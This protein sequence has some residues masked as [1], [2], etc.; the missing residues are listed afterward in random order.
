MT[1][2]R[3][4][5]PRH[6]SHRRCRGRDRSL[7]AMCR[8]DAASWHA[9]AEDAGAQGVHREGIAVS[10]CLACER[11][12]EPRLAWG[13]SCWRHAQVIKGDLDIYIIIDEV[14]CRHCC[15][16]GLFRLTVGD[17]LE[18]PTL[19]LIETTLL[20]DAYPTLPN[21]AEQ[22]HAGLLDLN[23]NMT[24]R[25]QHGCIHLCLVWSQKD[26]GNKCLSK[27]IR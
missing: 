20:P 11:G 12:F 16:I 17:L 26:R 24:S 13:A 9:T 23:A 25:S 19:K 22:I 15:K 4:C 1:G 27:Q 8:G 10:V 2:S 7:P 14:R 6:R 21:P 18:R 5:A 3:E